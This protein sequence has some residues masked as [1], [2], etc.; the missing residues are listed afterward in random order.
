M[1]LNK[2]QS[3]ILDYINKYPSSS[4][5]EIEE[6]I[7]SV[8]DIASKNTIIRDLDTLLK[9]NYIK[10]EGSAR[11]IKYLPFND[12]ELLIKYDVDNYF[13]I[14]T[15]ERKIKYPYFNFEIFNNLDKIFT[16]KEIAPHPSHHII[17]YHIADYDRF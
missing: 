8:D 10:K 5:L 11:S 12:N 17:S 1:K 6:Y 13:K 14:E 3:L 7:S 9:N 4:R 2:R 15:D 16:E